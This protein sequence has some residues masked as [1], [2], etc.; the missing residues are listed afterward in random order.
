MREL[1]VGAE[2]ADV[3]FKALA[4]WSRVWSWRRQCIR[5]RA[6]LAQGPQC[7]ELLHTPQI[8]AQGLGQTGERDGASEAGIDRSHTV[9][10]VGPERRGRHLQE[11]ARQWSVE[12]P[13][14]SWVS[15]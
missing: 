11:G 12:A 7:G 15:E 2:A 8:V 14:W 1:G 3:P 5:H 9:G 10:V 13:S 6:S 4:S